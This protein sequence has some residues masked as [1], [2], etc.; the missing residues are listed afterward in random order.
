[1]RKKD[2]ICNKITAYICEAL[3]EK[4]GSPRCK[5]IQQ[6]IKQCESCKKIIQSIQQLITLY[7]SY[8]IP[9]IKRSRS[10]Q[11]LQKEKNR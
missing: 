11:H 7:Q 5:Q 2:K 8:P 4:P 1:M 3:D 10:I 9:H 6:H